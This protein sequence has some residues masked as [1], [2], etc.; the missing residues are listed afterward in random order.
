MLSLFG[1]SRRCA[2]LFQ[3][4]TFAKMR[5]RRRQEARARI[6]F[7]WSL[8]HVEINALSFWRELE[9]LTF[10]P[11]SSSRQNEVKE[12][13]GGQSK[14]PLLLVFV[15]CGDKCSH[16]FGGSRSCCLLFKTTAPAKTRWS[17]LLCSYFLRSRLTLEIDGTTSSYLLIRMARHWICI[18]LDIIIG[19]ARAR[20]HR[21]VLNS[22]IFF[23]QPRCG[24]K[25]SK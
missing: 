3:S 7:F 5:W 13:A 4:P 23:H 25:F 16:F 18:L 24:H 14:D 12:M 6:P 19:E 15:M 8:W 11:I 20:I 21:F 2:L 17:L 10:V 22:L 1:R 9:L